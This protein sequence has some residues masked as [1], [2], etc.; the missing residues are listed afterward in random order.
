[1][2]SGIRPLSCSIFH[3]KCI[4]CVGGKGGGVTIVEMGHESW[5]RRCVR[6]TWQ[7][8]V[9]LL[10][11]PHGMNTRSCLWGPLKI[12]KATC[13]VSVRW[14]R[15]ELGHDGQ[16]AGS[17]AEWQSSPHLRYKHTNGL[18]SFVAATVKCVARASHCSVIHVRRPDD[19]GSRPAE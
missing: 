11:C 17:L 8:G 10:S 14:A 3:T 2:S 1:M 13:Q 7:H 9:T 16:V 5:N 18:P 6:V 15:R 19:W 12:S 4:V